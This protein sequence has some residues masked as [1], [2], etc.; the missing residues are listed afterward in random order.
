[1]EQKK[2]KIFPVSF[3]TVLVLILV[4]MALIPALI[5]SK[6]LS[7]S[8]SRS[9]VEARR[10]EIKNQVLILADKL[11]TSAY[12][13]NDEKDKAIEA[14][15][16][17]VAD[18]FDGRIVLI[19]A[20]FSVVKDTFN[21]ALGKK[22]I[23]EEVIKT[24]QGESVDKYNAKKNYIIQTFPIYRQNNNAVID[25]IVL[26]SSS[27]E[28]FSKISVS[29]TDR[30]VIFTVILGI[31]LV[32]AS[33]FVAGIIIKPFNTI[34]KGLYKISEGDLSYN[35]Q[36]DTYLLT[37]QISRALNSTMTKLRLINQ[38]RDE[39][40]SNVSHELKTP[41]TSIR[42]LADS[43]LSME[44]APKELYKEFMTDISEEIDREAKIIDDLLTLVKLDRSDLV[45]VT[46]K[47]NINELINV[48]LKRIRPI[49]AKQNV[50]L[51]FESMREVEAE[52]DETKFSLAI[53]NLVENAVKYNKPGGYVKVNL[54]ADHKFFYVKVMDNGVGIPEELQELIFDRFYRVDKARSKETGGTGLG[55]SITK[56]FIMKH[57]G[58]IRV[59]PTWGE[60]STFTVRIPLIQKNKA[61]EK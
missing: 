19:D 14:Q 15:I 46:K 51:T 32:A 53:N 27:T 48:I 57:G 47:V 20:N 10:L 18:V 43:L 55:L 30:A 54:D 36:E 9:M 37:S 39:F 35:I 8:F 11:S 56:N 17:S 3:R 26:I 58:I 28:D 34:R 60:G 5:D 16:D 41:I 22:S 42:V 38:S 44:D 4:F 2:I 50:G 13:L 25:G 45:L 40:V 1:M 59:N 49:A 21:L 61:M 23:A 24:F 12:L 29:A 31:L 6:V 52:I 7:R 33:V